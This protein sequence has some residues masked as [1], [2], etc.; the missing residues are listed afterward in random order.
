MAQAKEQWTDNKRC[1]GN[2]KNYW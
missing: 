2:S 1:Q